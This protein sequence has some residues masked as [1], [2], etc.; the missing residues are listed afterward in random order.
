MLFRDNKSL[1]GELAR[2]SARRRHL[3][4][5]EA[6]D[7]V[8]FVRV[9]LTDNDYEILHKF[10]NRSTLRTFLLA[11]IERL[12]LDFCARAWADWP[13]SVEAQRLGPVAVL[14]ERLKVRDRHSLI[15]AIRIMRREHGVT[16]T[17]QQIRLLW[18]A[19][20]EARNSRKRPN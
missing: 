18:R 10:K 7:L 5:R 20:Q 15:D 13:P 2:L 19:L 14:I 1:I 9:R 4:S 16:L 11:S 17:N 3:S 8:G 12:T 6:D